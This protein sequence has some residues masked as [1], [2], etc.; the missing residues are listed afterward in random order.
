[1][2]MRA[3]MTLVPLALVLA[4]T[5][6]A[7]AKPE[8]G[9]VKRV[10]VGQSIS[11]APKLQKY[12]PR[13]WQEIE[14]AAHDGNWTLV[15]AEDGT[16]GC[17]VKDCPQE[18]AE[19]EKAISLLSLEG[20][21]TNSGFSIIVKVWAKNGKNGRDGWVGEFTSE[22]ELCSAPEF[23]SAVG[24]NVRKAL[25]AEAERLIAPRPTPPGTVPT[26]QPAEVKPLPPVAATQP[27]PPATNLVSP[28]PASQPE[29]YIPR[30]VSVTAIVGG[31]ALI[32]SGIYLLHINGEGTCDLG[33]GQRLCSQHYKTQGL[34]TG[35]VVGGS[36][37]A[38]GGLAGL[39]F[40]PPG[41]WN[42]P[43]ALGFDGSSISV[44][45]AF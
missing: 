25:V 10:V 24:L 2:R 33:A 29:W 4:S 40:W 7:S 30:Y 21:Y 6:L 45:G 13:M 26:A 8:S 41:E 37:A 27:A 9:K 43:M 38:L 17:T 28:R 23:T 14:S 36:L 5:S 20:T 15:R 1:M 39:I 44:S 12:R 11:F 32:G 31:A 22:C 18:I 35:L 16:G 3:N 42:T 19:R 34:G